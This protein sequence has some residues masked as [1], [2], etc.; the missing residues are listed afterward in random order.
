MC[1]SHIAFEHVTC[2]NAMW[3]E[4]TSK[5]QAIPRDVEWNEMTSKK[6]RC[7]QLHSDMKRT[8]SRHIHRVTSHV[9]ISRHV[10]NKT[11]RHKYI[12][13]TS[14]T[15][16]TLIERTP[17]PPGKFPIYYVPAS[18]TVITLTED[19]PQSTWY[20]F[21]EGGPLTH[22]SWWGNIVNRKPPWNIVNRKPPQGGG[23]LSI[24]LHNNMKSTVTETYHSW[25]RHVTQECNM[26]RIDEGRARLA[27]YIPIYIWIY[28]HIYNYLCEKKSKRSQRIRHPQLHS[29]MNGNVWRHT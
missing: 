7:A 21:F 5:R 27:I 9:H 28:I 19:P 2:S 14:H 1:I 22:G 25:I 29:D 6:M 15:W 11:S 23:F 4:R 20:K 16:S 3:N 13:F 26:S 24:E 10:C 18:R 8:M 17:P 12:C